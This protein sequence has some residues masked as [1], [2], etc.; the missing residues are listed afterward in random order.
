MGEGRKTRP[1][2]WRMKAVS[3][4]SSAKVANLSFLCAVFVCVIHVRWTA[5][6]TCGRLLVSVCRDSV[7]RMAVP[8]FF[9]VSGFFLARHWEEPGW[10]RTAVVKRMRTLLVPYLAWLTVYAAAMLALT[11]RW[12]A[13]VGGYGLNP[14]RMP[15]LA[16]LWYVRCLM[17]FVLV[18]PW[19]VKAAARG[20]GRHVLAATFA[21]D[22]AFSV[23]MGLGVVTDETAVGGFLCYG[24]SLDGFLYFTLGACLAVAP[25]PPPSRRT[26][27]LC[28][29][30]A[31][32]LIAVR[33]V[34]LYAGWRLPIHLNVLIVPPLLAFAWWATPTRRLPSWLVR[35]A[36]PIF[37][38][39]GIVFSVI[40]TLG[41]FSGTGGNWCELACD[42]AVPVAVA[43]V[44][45]AWRPG[46][47]AFLFGGR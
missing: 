5:E 38:M 43:W 24:F 36:F 6:T 2:G 28:G 21:L 37:L 12:V 16:P 3:D 15:M 31:A 14:C 41:L 46:A 9:A 35:A 7:A 44:L 25:R 13:G 34:F 18:S 10:W 30:A 39:H 45:R 8:F 40:R 32:A 26:A 19:V 47:A 27:W 20:R 42:V 11:R 17:C 1:G 23:L 29:I 33:L 22:L 4:E